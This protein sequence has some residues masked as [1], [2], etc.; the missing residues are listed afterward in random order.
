MQEWL[1]LVPF[2]TDP[3]SYAGYPQTNKYV[4]IAAPHTSNWDFPLGI[5]AQSAMKLNT[6]W[7]GKHALQTPMPWF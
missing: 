5:I 7:I 1:N 2:G 6:Q 4:L 3:N